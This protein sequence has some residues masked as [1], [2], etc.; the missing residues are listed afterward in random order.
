METILNWFTSDNNV[1]DKFGGIFHQFL[2]LDPTPTDLDVFSTKWRGFFEPYDKYEKANFGADVESM[3]ISFTEWLSQHNRAT[4]YPLQ[5][6]RLFLKL[7]QYC[8]LKASIGKNMRV[9]LE[10]TQK[11]FPYSTPSQ[12]YQPAIDALSRSG[13][14]QEDLDALL[15]EHF[16]Y[17]HQNSSSRERSQ[18]VA[19]GFQMTLAVLQLHIGLMGGRIEVSLLDWKRNLEIIP[20][21]KSSGPFHRTVGGVGDYHCR[22]LSNKS[23]SRSWICEQN[24][25][26]QP[27]ESL[28]CAIDDIKVRFD[29]F[30][31][32]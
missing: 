4:M 22:N 3:V 23:S 31:C 5:T 8:R 27:N 20:V 13:K 11:H 32:E 17:L 28:P 10:E 15:K 12:W 16:T 6:L 30:D 9:L 26:V 7:K 24:I 19:A 21:D 14:L 18:P 25:E 29:A 2:Q 1:I